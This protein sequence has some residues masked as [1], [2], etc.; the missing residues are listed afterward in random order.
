MGILNAL[1]L[2]D[3]L[4][5]E[6]DGKPDRHLAVVACMDAR[7]DVYRILGLEVGDANVIR[8]AGGVIT[9]DVI[10]SLTVSQWE[11]ET[12][13][14]VL[15]HHTKCGMLGF[16]EPEFRARLAE[17]AG[18]RPEWSADGFDDVE[19]DVRESI[20]RIELNPFLKHKHRVLGYVYD[21]DTRELRFVARSQ[22][23]Q[24]A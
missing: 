23:L 10:R 18:A 11:L 13:V 6:L 19:R 2:P 1:R 15:I 17:H 12:S 3:D 20:R 7:M 14:I 9:D 5:T 8:N 21:V 16:K 22:E 4:T 24:A